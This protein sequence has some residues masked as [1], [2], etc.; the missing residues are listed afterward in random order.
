MKNRLMALA[1]VLVMCLGLVASAMA[2]EISPMAVLKT[3]EEPNNSMATANW[4]DQDD[5]F[6]GH[7]SPANDVDY[8]KIVPSTNGVFNFWL[9]NIPTG[10]NYELY[11]YNSSGALLACSIETGTT[12]KLISGITATKGS[13]YYFAVRGTNG[14]YSAT[15]A[16]TL[17]CRLL[18][19]PYAGFSQTDP[20]RSP[21]SFSTTNLNNLYSIGGDK[22]WLSLYKDK[23]CFIASYAM[24]LRNLGATTKDVRYDFRSSIS[25]HLTADP[26]TVMLANTSWPTISKNSNGKYYA[27]ISQ[28]PVY[29]YHNR[30]AS[31][32]RKAA[33]AVSL[34]S[35]LSNDDKAKAIAYYLSKHPEGVM[36]TFCRTINTTEYTHTVVFTQ[37]TV[38][39]PSSYT[40]PAPYQLLS[41]D[42]SVASE[43]LEPM[44]DQ[45]AV[46]ANVPYGDAFVVCDPYGKSYYS[47]PESFGTSYAAATYNGLA[48]ANGIYFLT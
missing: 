7:I 3:E 20:G 4:A 39:I 25:S 38:E 1:L 19:N 30:I 44:T 9:G 17:R 45:I 32:F 33:N 12:Q 2:S 13:T 37:T 27:N 36:V 14:S 48:Y 5:T 16:Y 46:A 6:T 47:A 40:P 29:V 41:A 35:N 21:T 26:F 31:S 28:S 42:Y 18:M 11:V 22:S 43:V 34:G 8:F 24:V 15:S 10:K 23:G